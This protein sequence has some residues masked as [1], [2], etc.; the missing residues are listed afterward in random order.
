MGGIQSIIFG[1]S[2]TGDIIES[3]WTSSQFVTCFRFTPNLTDF[4]C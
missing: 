4:P 3:I 1:G 2:E